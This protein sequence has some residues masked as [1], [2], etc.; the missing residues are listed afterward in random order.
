[1]T[2]A[3]KKITFTLMI[4]SILALSGQ[5]QG[6]DFWQG[7]KPKQEKPKEQPK[8]TPKQGGNDRGGRGGDDR[9]RGKKP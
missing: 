4:S 1:M 3:L 8:E 2:N 5:A 6:N 9:G 7:G